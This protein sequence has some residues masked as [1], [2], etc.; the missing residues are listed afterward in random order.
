[1][2]QRNDNERKYSVGVLCLCGFDG[3]ISVS[4]ISPSPYTPCKALRE[5]YLNQVLYYTRHR[6]DMY[7]NVVK[8]LT[9][10][11]Y[12]IERTKK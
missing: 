9:V 11:I 1:M 6:S 10:K 3:Y 2:S 8:A 5:F 7:I 4:L 12:D